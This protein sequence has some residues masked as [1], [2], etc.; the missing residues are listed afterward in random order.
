M[1]AG[2]AL[3]TQNEINLLSKKVD[4][5]G[6]GNATFN[7]FLLCFYQ[8]SQKD[9]SEYAIKECF[10]PFDK[11]GTGYINIEELKHVM[12]NL[13]EGLSEDEMN[14]FLENFAGSAQGSIHMEDLIRVLS[15]K[16]DM[17]QE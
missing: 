2:G 11:E 1:R 15:F 13:G 10:A 3:I 9:L 12:K 6:S 5:Y 4:P 8:I 17:E 14:L 16:P 7:D